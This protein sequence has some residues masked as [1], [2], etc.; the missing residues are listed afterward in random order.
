MQMAENWKSESLQYAY[1]PGYP[2]LT[3]RLLDNFSHTP[4]I[5]GLTWLKNVNSNH[6]CAFY[7][8][9]TKRSLDLASI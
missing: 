3:H 1:S 5:H 8:T 9:M 4:F 2:Q 7:M 6:S